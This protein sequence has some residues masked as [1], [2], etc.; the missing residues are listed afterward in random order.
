[1]LFKNFF[2]LSLFVPSLKRKKPEAI[3]KKGTAVRARMRVSIKFPV[4]LISA[5]GEVCIITTSTAA[6]SLKESNAG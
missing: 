2:S 3:K 4:S 6:A 5:R 1:M